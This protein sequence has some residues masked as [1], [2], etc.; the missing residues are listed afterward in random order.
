M[1]TDSSYKI[2]SLLQLYGM[3]PQN[4]KIVTDILRQIIIE[5]L[6][7]EYKKKYLTMFLSFMV[8]EVS[9]QLRFPG[10]ELKK[11]FY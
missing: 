8:K 10:A 3:L 5:N 6:P 4:E 11:V 2:K 1:K 7:E 9:G